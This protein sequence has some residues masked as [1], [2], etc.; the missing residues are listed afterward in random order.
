MDQSRYY[1]VAWITLRSGRV[2]VL[3]GLKVLTDG[4]QFS[5]WVVDAVRAINQRLDPDH[6]TVERA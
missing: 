6:D 3:Q 4:V 2:Q 5:T 1:V